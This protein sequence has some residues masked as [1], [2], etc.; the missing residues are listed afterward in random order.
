[1]LLPGIV[2]K[3]L[4]YIFN[5][6]VFTIIILLEIMPAHKQRKWNK[7]RIIEVK[8]LQNYKIYKI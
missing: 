5:I 4:I 2:L 8:K 1:M 7:N 6:K 3:Y